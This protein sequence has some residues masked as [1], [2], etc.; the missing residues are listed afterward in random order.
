MISK[1][2]DKILDLAKNMPW[3]AWVIIA[4]FLLIFFIPNKRELVKNTISILI[5][6][7]HLPK[8]TTIKEML[9]HAKEATVLIEL[10]DVGHGSGVIIS[11]DGYIITNFHVIEE[12]MELRIKLSDG[13]QYTP[14]IIH[15]DE[16]HDLA[17]LK[18]KGTSFTALPKAEK[19]TYDIGDEVFAIGAPWFRELQ[20]TITKGI[21]SAFRK[22]GNSHQIQSDAKINPG[23]SGGPLINNKGELI[24]INTSGVGVDG[25]TS[26]VEFSIDINHAFKRLKLQYSD[27]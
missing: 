1:L 3:W 8:F 20:N 4:V 21:I 22:D 19:E 17:L 18:I 12:D 11:N 24:A 27:E 13:K 5:K 15:M 14:K 26:G 16:N 23:N 10:E 2:L 7:P 6:K 25:N 9:N